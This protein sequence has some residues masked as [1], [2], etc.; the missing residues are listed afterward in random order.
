MADAKKPK[1]PE[2][3]AV[4]REASKLESRAGEEDAGKDAEDDENDEEGG[5]APAEAEPDAKEKVD[6]ELLEGDEKKYKELNKLK[7]RIIQDEQSLH[8][9]QGKPALVLFGTTGSGKSTLANAFIQGSGQ[10]EQRNGLFNVKQDLQWNDEK[11][12]EIGHKVK[13]QTKAPKFH[14][15]APDSEIYL[16]DGP[17]INDSN[18]R[19]EYANQ[20]GIKYVLKNCKSFMLLIIMDANQINFEGGKSII[21]LLTAVVRKFTLQ[22]PPKK[23]QATAPDDKEDKERHIQSEELQK[24]IYPYFVN[25]QAIGSKRLLDEKLNYIKDVF[26]EKL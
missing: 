24:V 2:P 22:L 14:P 4:A 17:G 6:E 10:I 3:A 25:F 26:E 11:I 19:I 18:Y 20:T 16:V 12:F 1:Q 15:F 23:D 9:L 8:Q 5:P 13:S 7:T 21:E